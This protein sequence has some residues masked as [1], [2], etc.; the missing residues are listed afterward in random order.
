MKEFLKTLFKLNVWFFA[1]IMVVDTYSKVC[2][3]HKT[4]V[5]HK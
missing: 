5:K 1:G 2:D 3:I 4:I